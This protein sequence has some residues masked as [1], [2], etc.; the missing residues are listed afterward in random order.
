VI[1]HIDA[2]KDIFD[3]QLHVEKTPEGTAVLLK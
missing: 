2:L 1:T 3:T